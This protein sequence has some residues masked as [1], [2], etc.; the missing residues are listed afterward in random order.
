[1]NPP[2]NAPPRRRRW[3]LAL[4]VL[5][6]AGVGGGLFGRHWWARQ[7]LRTAENLLADMRFE[8]ASRLLDD[9]LRIRP[10]DAE[11]RLAAAR[12]KRRAGDP[13]A[14]EYHLIEF[15]RLRG[16]TP[17]SSLERVLLLAERGALGDKEVWLRSRLEKG[18]P[19]AVLLLEALAR[20][21]QTSGRLEDALACLDALLEECPLHPRALV[22]RAQIWGR[23]RIWDDALEDARRAVEL[24]PDSLEARLIWAEANEHA[25]QTETAAR[26]YAWL[27]ER[28]QRSPGVVLGLGR[29]WQ[30]LARF[31]EARQVLDAFLAEQ[32]A[33]ADVLV[34]RGRLALREGGTTPAEPYFRRA[35]VA[36][37]SNLDAHRFL[38]RCLEASGNPEEAARVDGQLRQLEIRASRN[39][40]SRGGVQ[41]RDLSRGGRLDEAARL[42]RAG[43]PAEAE[44]LLRPLTAGPSS[45][46]PRAFVGLAEAREAQGDLRGALEAL[47]QA[48]KV[49]PKN[50]AANYQ[51]G[52]LHFQAG[53]QLWAAGRA[54]GARAEFREAVTWLDNA[55]AVD[56]DFGKGLLLKG[57]ALS[58]FLG[59][60]EDGIALLRRFVQLRPEVGEGHLLLG[61]ALAD[62]GQADAAAASLRRAAELAPP[63]D[64]RAADAL[65][66]LGP[67]GRK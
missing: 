32:P 29:C 50:L 59:Q 45:T 66:K 36:D 55:L 16:R 53:E 15:E 62:A 2:R 17:V 37:P 58:R 9:Y 10:S 30:D 41:S 64:H 4:G 23:L 27:Y 61:Q 34:E 8:E 44:R 28:G 46:D 18:G 57:A 14:A 7:Q 51:I 43:K 65:A 24:R 56:P 20:D 67:P 60:K 49:D 19:D 5:I 42:L 63:G 26:A 21:Y 39:E 54:D 6:L 1:M 3:F 31:A 11:A 47:K 35:V 38:L 13:E 12:A 48:V 40:Q 22:W 33:R 52:L 25:G